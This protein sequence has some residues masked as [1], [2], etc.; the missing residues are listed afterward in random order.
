MKL[1]KVGF[2]K[3]NI[4]SFGNQFLIGN[5]H[6]GYRGTLEEY[7]K[8]D[9]VG[10]N[11]IGEYDQYQDK[12]RE[13]LNF[14]NPFKINI[15]NKSTL[16]EYNLKTTKY[17][18]HSQTL[19][20]DKAIHSRNTVYDDLTI[21][22][23]R[24]ILDAKHDL[25][26][27]KYQVETKVDCLIKLKVDLDIFECN[28]PHFKNTNIT[29]KNKHH[30]IDYV[31]N[32]NK[33][34]YQDT[35][36][37]F[38][39]E[40]RIDDNTIIIDLKQNEK[41]TICIY[42]SINQIVDYKLNYNELL[43]KHNDEW[44][45]YWNI[46]EVDIKGDAKANFNLNYSIY[47]LLILANS[48]YDT[49]IP[50][51]GL[52]GETYKGAIFWDTEIFMLPF[53]TLT[54]PSVAQSLIRYRVKSL[55]GAMEKA[56]E[57]GFD[58]AF[59]AW[60]SQEEGREACSKYN[61]THPVTGEPLRTYFGEKQIHI[62][63]DIVYAIENYLNVTND[64]SVLMEEA[65]SLIEEVAKFYLSYVTRQDNIYHVLD[66]IGPDEYHEGVNDNAY[67]NYM[68]KMV[69]DICIKYSKNNE[70]I[71]QIKEVNN[72]L[73]LPQPDKNNIIEQFDGYH[74]LED[75]TVEAV[76]S[77][78]IH[79]NQ[80]WGGEFGPATSTK[81]IKQADVVTLLVLLNRLFN[82]DIKKANF[83]YYY[84]YTE[85]GSSLSSCMYSLLASNI[86]YTDAAYCM[87]MKSASIDLGIN[88][89]IWAGGIYIGGTH[90]ASNAGSYLSTI[91]GFCGL[92]FIDN[93]II[94]NPHLPK[95]IK[96]IKFKIYYLGKLYQIIVNKNTQRI[97]EIKI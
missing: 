46:A 9:L 61:V 17:L 4:V 30:H 35:F 3:D 36:Y 95:K 85:H 52:S 26:C 40:Y 71:D 62:S 82:K 29:F 84:P 81:V 51:R 63:A 66:V 92:E 72:H 76:R 87:F 5:G 86:G 48:N 49:S 91:F 6:I 28:G 69:F 47:Q 44:N 1:V 83:D 80:Y 14:A 11:M 88:Q 27:L 68:I 16:K 32:E 41:L 43:K 96:E 65:I 57:L 37:S 18:S 20:I 45:K 73:Y 39:H 50:A 13:S 24:F 12:W 25:L 15:Y 31:T 23:S 56:T 97:E 33:K 53:F 77:R 64:Y 42:S 8:E 74:N 75:T 59:Y 38:K 93:K 60:E 58:G 94:L 34:Y 19:N 10:L 54:L 22:S 78:L 79:P 67:T 89:K 90:P 7:D 70:L 55:K 2:N 21:K